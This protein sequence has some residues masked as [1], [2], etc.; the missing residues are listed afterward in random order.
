MALQG[1]GVS[2]YL[3]RQLLKEAGFKRRKLHKTKCMGEV[4][5]RNE[6]FEHIAQLKASFLA[7]GLPVLSIDSKKKELLGDFY[8]QGTHY[9]QVARKVNDHDFPSMADG[10]IVPHGI[11]DLGRNY[12]Y[13]TLGTSK[14]TS[15]FVCDNIEYFWLNELQWHYPEANALLLLC[16]GGGANNCRHYR[17]KQDLWQLAQRLQIHIVVAHYPAYCSKWNPIEHRLFCH[18]SRAWNGAVFSNISHVKELALKTS[19]KT[20]LEVAVWINSKVYQT[21]RK[22]AVEFKHYIERFIQFADKLPKW[23]YAAFCKST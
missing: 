14:D 15:A 19:T 6:Q 21:K 17:F 1:I 3:V 2:L 13:I 9:G 23:N 16:D 10:Q 8:R 18:L 12:G 5:D 20:G 11:Y 4:E 22:Y 7:R